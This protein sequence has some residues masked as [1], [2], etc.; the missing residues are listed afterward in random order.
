MARRG[1]RAGGIRK[2]NRVQE[3]VVLSPID[4]ECA[5]KGIS[6]SGRIDGGDQKWFDKA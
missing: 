3:V 6:R 2:S 5:R 4:C 1:Q